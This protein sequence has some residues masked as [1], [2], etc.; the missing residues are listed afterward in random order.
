MRTLLY[1]YYSYASARLGLQCS[2]C[3]YTA[4]DSE[5]ALYGR[6]HWHTLREP[7]FQT[8]CSID[9]SV[10][11]VLLLSFFVLVVVVVVE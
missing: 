10:L 5:R 9:L 6:S 3:F 11:S 1:Y 2:W 8:I 4:R 7:N